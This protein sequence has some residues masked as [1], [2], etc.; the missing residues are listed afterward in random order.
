[1]TMCCLPS[2]STMQVDGQVQVK[3]TC[4]PLDLIKF[5]KRDFLPMNL[6][7]ERAGMSERG[8]YDRTKAVFEYFNLPFDAE[9]PPATD[10]DDFPQ[11]VRR[12][13]T[14]GAMTQTVRERQEI[15]EV[16][17]KR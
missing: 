14:V 15:Q 4:D 5:I 1:M 17:W 13:A 10:H 11:Q 3:V 12:A 16:L 6:I 9:P 7:C 8:I 2:I